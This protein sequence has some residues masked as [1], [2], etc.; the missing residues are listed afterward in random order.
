MKRNSKHSKKILQC[1][2]FCINFL[3][4][5]KVTVPPKH[6][7]KTCL[8]HSKLF[9][10]LAKHSKRNSKHLK[11][12]LQCLHFC[13]NFLLINKV[14]VPPKHYKK[15]C[16]KHSKLFPQL[17]KHSKRNSKHST[18]KT[19]QCLHFCIDFLL[20][21]KVTVHSQAL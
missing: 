4:K 7:K 17:A 13:I 9:P 12:T 11:K 16:I 10:E 19:L 8:K 1:L 18:K 14:T 2:H 15:T 6:Y 21:N 5:N 3:L 20:K